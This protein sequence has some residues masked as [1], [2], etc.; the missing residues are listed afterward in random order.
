MGEFVYVYNP[1]RKPGLSWNSTDSGQDHI[2]L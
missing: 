2:G 1:A